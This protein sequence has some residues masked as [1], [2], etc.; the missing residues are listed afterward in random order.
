MKSVTA[1]IIKRDG[2]YL[3][4]RRAPRENLAGFWEFPGGK[5]EANET[6]ED[7]LIRELREELQLET[8]VLEHFCN[9]VYQYEK[10]AINLMTCRTKILDGRNSP[11]TKYL[12]RAI[13]KEGLL[14]EQ[15]FEDV[16]GN[17]M[18]E[19]NGKQVFWGNSSILG[20]FYFVPK[21]SN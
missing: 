11:Y 5:I 21:K 6:P 9:S 2:R 10:G 14:L 16:R 4:A 3:L 7:C 20:D 1:A 19:T 12:I 17:V 18:K 15:V 8:R 13:Q